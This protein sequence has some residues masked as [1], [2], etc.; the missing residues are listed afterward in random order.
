[1]PRRTPDNWAFLIQQWKKSGQS[2]VDFCR[3]NGLSRESFYKWAKALAKESGST[4]KATPV[5]FLEIEASAADR[6]DSLGLRCL[7][8]ITSYG[9]ILEIPL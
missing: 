2:K 7:R 1:M 9:T 4:P 3:E 5:N 6:K 8:I